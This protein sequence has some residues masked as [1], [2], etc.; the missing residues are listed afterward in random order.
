MEESAAAYFSNDSGALNALCRRLG[1]DAEGACY[2][3]YAPNARGYR[4]IG[5][6]RVNIDA[7]QDAEFPSPTRAFK[8]TWLS[9]LANRRVSRSTRS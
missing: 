2:F 3:R 1:K 8:H 5:C 6:C 4:M 7:S 9:R